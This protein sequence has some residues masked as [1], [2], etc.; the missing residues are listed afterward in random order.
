MIINY[1]IIFTRVSDFEGTLA[2]ELD[3]IVLFTTD[4]H[5]LKAVQL[6]VAEF[7]VTLEAELGDIVEAAR[8]ARFHW[9]FC[10]WKR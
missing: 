2:E 9:S 1:S 10:V 8:Y 5:L 4:R 3:E 7:R 6:F